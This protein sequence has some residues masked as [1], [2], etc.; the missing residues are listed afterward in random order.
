MKTFTIGFEEAG[1]N[2]AIY[3]K[4]VARHLGTEHHEQ[5]VTFAEARHVIPL[6]P[7]MYDEPFADSSPNS[8]SPG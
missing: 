6:L 3:A 8:Y 7:A 4:E 2:E 5:Y 1:F